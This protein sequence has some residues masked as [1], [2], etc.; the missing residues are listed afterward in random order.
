MYGFN[1]EVGQYVEMENF[2]KNDVSFTIKV[3]QNIVDSQ[4]IIDP[5]I[6]IA[7]IDT[8][9]SF[10]SAAFFEEEE[11]QTKISVSLNLKINSFG[12]MLLDET[13][14]MKIF[15][16]HS[17]KKFLLFEIHILDKDNNVVKLATHLKK[18]VKAKF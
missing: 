5:G 3:T 4:N 16:K 2:D 18:T 17:K 9:S 14:K 10:S 1:L 12:D 7:I 11:E 13:Y 15:L 8:F 6:L